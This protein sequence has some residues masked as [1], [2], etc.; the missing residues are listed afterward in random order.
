MPNKV[1]IIMGV[2]GSGKTT[3]GKMLAEK[4]RF[5]FYDADNFHPKEN[6]EKMQAGIPLTD[7][8]RWPWLDNMNNFAKEKIKTGNVIVTCSAL[9]EIYRLRLC[10][11]IETS[12][13][14]IFLKGTYDM[15]LQRMQQRK[16][17]YMPASLLQSQFDALE[18]PTGAITEDI[19]QSPEIIVQRIIKA[20]Y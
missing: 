6:I 2:S 8:D 17:H 1:I 9:K 4:T 3:I 20:I 13:R 15:I 11:G 7:E 19:S 16:E 14:W 12:C 18:E 5:E 10:K